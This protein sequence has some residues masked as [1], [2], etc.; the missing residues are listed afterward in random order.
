MPKGEIAYQVH[1]LTDTTRD[2]EFGM[3]KYKGSINLNEEN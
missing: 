2:I 3:V 1:V